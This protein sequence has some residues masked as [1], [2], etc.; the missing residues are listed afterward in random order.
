[1]SRKPQWN[2]G[3]FIKTLVYFNRPFSWLP[4]LSG[5]SSQTERGN[6]L[7]ILVAGATGGVGQRVVRR[8]VERGHRVR[9]LVRDKSR[10]HKILGDRVELFAADITIPETLTLQM[11]QQVEAVIC[12]TGVKVQPVEG[13]TPKRE[14]YYQG[15]KFYLPEVVDSPE[16]VDYQGIQNLV[17]AVR[18]HLKISA[19]QKLLCDFTDTLLSVEDTWGAVDDVVMGGV[20]ESGIYQTDGCAAFSGTV[21]TENNGGFASVRTRNFQSPLDLSVYQGVELQVRGD[22]KRYKF[23]LRCEDKWDGVGYSYSFDTTKN[24][25]IKIQVPFADLIP[26]FRAKTVAE[27]R[28][29][30]QHICSMQL[31]LSKFEYDGDLN[32]RFEPGAFRLEVATIK[33]YGG[34]ATPQFVMVSSAGVTRPGRPDLDLEEEPPAVR[35]NDQLGGILT[36]KLRGEEAVRKSGLSYTIVRPCALT[37]APGDKALVVDQGDTMKGQVSRE[38]IAELCIEAL[39]HSSACD[40]TFEV[41]EGENGETDWNSLFASLESD[42]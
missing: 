40:K 27:A 34:Q 7:V 30:P 3:R 28:L 26:V 31:M 19:Q 14:K 1:M 9:A 2:L 39:Q 23:I 8:L 10:A 6:P 12:C 37:E 21:S 25:W 38:A 36:W 5:S 33:A 24:S 15:V 22:G 29:N 20:S 42:C 32:P 11:M 41:R 4:Q 17:Q 16:I 18:Q 13:D 35:M